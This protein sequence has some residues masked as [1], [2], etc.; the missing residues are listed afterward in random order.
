MRRLI[1]ADILLGAVLQ[2]RQAPSQGHRTGRSRCGL[3]QPPPG[4]RPPICTRASLNRSLTPSRGVGSWA[5]PRASVTE[6]SR[7]VES[8]RRRWYAPPAWRVHF[9]AEAGQLIDRRAPA[10][11]G[12]RNQSSRAEPHR[13]PRSRQQGSQVADAGIADA[14]GVGG[15]LGGV[16]CASFASARAVRKRDGPRG[17]AR[18]PAHA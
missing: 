9:W 6:E 1:L 18:P 13:P 12:Q 3:P 15:A 17:A 2:G 16:V 5:R 8:P 10:Q 7:P 14:L 4:L 11:S